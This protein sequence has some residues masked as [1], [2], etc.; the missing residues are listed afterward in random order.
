VGHF[1]AAGS[2]PIA[3][4]PGSA[5]RHG[6]DFFDAAL[7]MCQRLNSRG[8]FLSRHKDHVPSNLPPEVLHVDFVPFS[9]LLPSCSAIVHHGGIGTCAQGLSAGIPQLVISMSH[10]QPDNGRRLERLGVGA[11]IPAKKFTADRGAAVMK[12]LMD[13]QHRAT[14]A[15]VQRLVASENPFHRTAGVVECLIN[16]EQ[17][18]ECRQ[19]R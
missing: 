8:I 16:C 9:K 15:K 14:C 11:V 13:E 17:R 7:G 6:D 1:L 2:P 19:S 18:A 10:D 12:R 4:T 5:M 3:F